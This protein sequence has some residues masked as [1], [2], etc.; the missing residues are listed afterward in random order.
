MT[1]CMQPVGRGGVAS[2][3][4]GAVGGRAALLG[5]SLDFCGSGAS[6]ALGGRAGVKLAAVRVPGTCLRR[7]PRHGRGSGWELRAS[8]AAA[9]LLRHELRVRLQERAPGEAAAALGCTRG[10][11]RGAARGEASVILGL[12]RRRHFFWAGDVARAGEST[13]CRKA[14]MTANRRIAFLRQMSA[15]PWQ[16]TSLRSRPRGAWRLWHDAKYRHGP[17]SRR[18]HDREQMA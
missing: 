8:A 6:Q 5:R 7:A 15:A 18:R 9:G 16:S 12:G 13:S 14:R 10:W 17:H 11:S 2:S 1:S 4:C 3:A